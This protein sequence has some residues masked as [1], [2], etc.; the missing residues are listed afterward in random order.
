MNRLFP[1]DITE[2]DNSE[3][4]SED[5][6]EENEYSKLQKCIASFTKTQAAATVGQHLSIDKRVQIAGS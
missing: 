1:C 6:E 2:V 3:D 4:D 5:V